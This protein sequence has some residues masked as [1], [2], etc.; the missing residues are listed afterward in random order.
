MSPLKRVIE[1]IIPR[2]VKHFNDP[3][4]RKMLNDLQI[5]SVKSQNECLKPI[6]P[7]ATRWNSTYYCICRI[8]RFKAFLPLVDL[9]FQETDWERLNFSKYF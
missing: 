5:L 4:N 7:N 9:T 6:K 1:F 2:F 8:I 3:D